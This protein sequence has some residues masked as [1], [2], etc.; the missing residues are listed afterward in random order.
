MN[1]E[2]SEIALNG[3][4]GK[5]QPRS[6]GKEVFST[7]LRVPMGKNY[8]GTT[9]MLPVPNYDHKSMEVELKKKN[10]KKRWKPKMAVPF[11]GNQD[12]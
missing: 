2:S 4:K 7:V 1:E 11:L 12:N 10:K 5:I 3:Q 8:H 6:S 9:V